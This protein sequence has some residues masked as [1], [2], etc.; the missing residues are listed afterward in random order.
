M[1]CGGQL[2]LGVTGSL[3]SVIAAAS[4]SS[5]GPS[6][7]S[8]WGGGVML[9][10]WGHAKLQAKPV[11]L[12]TNLDPL[13]HPASN[14]LGVVVTWL[15]CAASPPTVSLRVGGVDY[16]SQSATTSACIR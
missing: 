3:T 6:T 2:A 14:I 8:S 10:S 7:A 4:A 12:V 9:L 13:V 5:T 11:T 16:N 1:K 15:C